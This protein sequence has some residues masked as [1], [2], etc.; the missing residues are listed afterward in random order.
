MSTQPLKI[1]NV[2]RDESLLKSR[3]AILDGAGYEVVPALTILKVQAACESQS[4]DLVIIGYALPKDEKR[5]VMVAVRKSCGL[6][7]ILELYS[8]GTVPVDQEADEEL[9]TRGEADVL[10]AKVKELLAKPRKRRQVAR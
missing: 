6:T 8:P 5:R 9:V 2:A 3:S 10:L 1:L 7:P 4:F